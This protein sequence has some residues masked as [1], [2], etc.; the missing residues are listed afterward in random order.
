MVGDP[1]IDPGCRLPGSCVQNGDCVDSLSC[2]NGQCSDPC[3]SGVS[4]HC[5]PNAVCNVF[6]H[7]AICSCPVG[8]LGDPTD[9]QL[10]CFKV[11]CTTDEDCSPEKHCDVSSN[12]CTS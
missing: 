2:V 6:D 8:H 4:T 3:S 11:E 1:F 12:K 10:G 9:T 5:G 7:V